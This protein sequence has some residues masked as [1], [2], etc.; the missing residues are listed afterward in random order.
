MN[1]FAHL[2]LA[3][4]TVESRVGNLLGDFARGVDIQSLPEE[5][6]E[7]LMNH[8]RVDQFTDQHPEVIQLKGYFSVQRRRFSGIAL[9]VLFDH[10]MLK[11]W[12]QFSH[13]PVDQVI[14]TLY[15]DLIAGQSLMP[16]RMQLVTQ[17]L[18]DTDWFRAYQEL[19]GVAY[20]LDRIAGRIRFRH[21]FNGIGEELILHY[22]QLEAG[23]SV[24]FVDLCDRFP[25]S[26]IDSGK[27][28]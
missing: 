14:E 16:E 22:P 25:S 21:D 20:A 15:E 6:R 19:D 28:A 26:L 5:V 11:H 2:V 9:D 12:Q 7:G 1:F 8:R 18:V 13:V 3:K 23:F 4:P 17:R 10:F 27:R 24:F